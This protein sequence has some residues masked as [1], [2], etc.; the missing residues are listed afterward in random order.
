MYCWKQTIDDEKNRILPDP[1]SE[2]RIK[3]KS[4]VELT[5]H[6]VEHLSQ[7][8]YT[9]EIESLAAGPNHDARRVRGST[10]LQALHTDDL[11][12]TV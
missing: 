1:V 10:A 12:A 9:K 7:Y 3:L 8:K 4:V 6:S 2:K 11:L 5:G